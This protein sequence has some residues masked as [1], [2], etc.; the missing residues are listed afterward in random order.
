EAIDDRHGQRARAMLRFYEA[1]F[2]ELAATQ[3]AGRGRHEI[4]I[5]SI[6]GLF[7]RPAPAKAIDALLDAAIPGLTAELAI[8]PPQ[9][10]AQCWRAALAR[11]RD[12]RLVSPEDPRRPGELDA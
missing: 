8:L 6:L 10:R 5:L 2:A 12:L 11:L 1:R 4:A 7:D 9:Q 3:V